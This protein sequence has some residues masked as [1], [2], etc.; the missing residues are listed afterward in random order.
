MRIVMLEPLAVDE[1]VLN[2]L[3]APLI[4]QGHEFVACQQKI[5]TETAK[6]AN[7]DV[8]IIANSPLSG[9]VIRANTNLKFISVGFTGIDHVDLKVCKEQGIVI[10]N[11]QGYC[12]DA[13]AELTFGHIISVLRNIT[14]CDAITRQKGTKAGLVGHELKEKTIGIVGTGA[15]GTRV[16]EIA[17]VFGCT[18]LGYNRTEH[19]EVK[20]LG[21]HHVP[22]EQ[23]M[24]KSDIV[25]LHIPLTSETKLLIN[26]DRIA[27]MKP[28]AVLINMARGA[29]VDSEALAQA[30]NDQKIAGAGIDVFETEPPLP[31]NHPLLHAK[32][33]LVTPHVAFATKESMIRRAQITFDNIV[34]WLINPNF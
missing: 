31:S 17:T 10:K 5:D 18:V 2:S 22:L 12:T 11:A 7:A 14:A 27:L 15:I 13:V 34:S 4:K 19:P 26:K 8:L 16:A 33:V 24:S 29:V 30:L 23:L 21:V 6:K 32:N 9:E 25:T 28:S 20:R 1:K 3:A